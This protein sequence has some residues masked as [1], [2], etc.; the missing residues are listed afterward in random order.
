MAISDN[1]VPLKEL[2]NGTT[3]EFSDTWA[4][5]S[6]SFLRVF[7]E[8]VTTGVQVLQTEGSDYTLT[9]DDSGFVVTFLTAPTSANFVVISREVA[10]DQTVPY[11]T[12]KGFQ[13]SVQEGSFDKAAAISQDQQ[14]DIDRSLGFPIGSSAVGSLPTPVDD[15][16]VG[17]NST[18]GAQKNSVKTITEVENT[19]DS[20]N[21]LVAGSGVLVSADDTTVGFLNGKLIVGDVITN[22]WP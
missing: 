8:D 2:G 19:V 17:W 4:V 13:G 18:T 20:V 12:S 1:Y 5:L 22:L 14:D 6:A 11:T 10:I 21:G 3:T 16:F 9:F 7:L 15:L